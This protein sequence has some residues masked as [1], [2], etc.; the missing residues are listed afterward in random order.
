MEY[1]RLL[2]QTP[3]R[4]RNPLTWRL[5]GTAPQGKTVLSCGAA[6]ILGPAL[7]EMGIS[8][9]L[10]LAGSHVQHTPGGQAVLRCLKEAGVSCD[11]FTDIPSE[12]HFEVLCR[13]QD[14]VDR[15]HQAVAGLG[16][17][18]VMDLAKLAAYGGMDLLARVKER[19]FALEPA[20]PLFLLPTTAG[21][22]R[23]ISPYSVLTVEGRKVFYASPS[24]L[25]TAALVD[26]LLTV[27]MPPHV[28]AATAFDAMTHALEGAMARPSPYTDALAV[29]SAAQILHYLPLALKDGQDIPARCHLALASVMGMM[30]YVM[31]GG[32]YAHSISYILTLEKGAPHGVGCGLSLPYTMAFNAEHIQ[33]LLD[34]L[35][36]RC[37][38]A[39]GGEDTRRQVIWHIQK[40]FAAAG[41]PASLEKLG[42]TAADI[43]DLAG[44]LL[45]KYVRK[46]NPRPLSPEDARRLFA[47]MLRGSIEF[48]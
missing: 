24:L 20:L 22:G 29:E 43:P 35:A 15:R 13:L 8:R 1:D 32:L 25:P 45:E 9:I 39:S 42:Y 48:F 40:A 16:G 19:N 47:A 38:G 23:E 37:L 33:P 14:A 12:P 26:P 30:S 41:L 31:G 7:R 11:M 46:N 44:T 28:T 18:S 3:P 4:Y 2:E 21:T 10:L 27:S 36:A 5:P 6:K 34:K 17:G